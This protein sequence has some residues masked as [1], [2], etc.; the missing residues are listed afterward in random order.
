MVTLY[1]T[2]TSTQTVKTD[3]A[4]HFRKAADF[5]QP[6]IGLNALCPCSGG[7]FVHFHFS[8]ASIWCHQLPLSTR[9]IPSRSR[10]SL[11][12]ALCS[13]HPGKYTLNPVEG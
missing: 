3:L 5:L 1:E 6:R 9:L 13:C 8:S 11:F 4:A 10:P 7:F 12:S 2:S